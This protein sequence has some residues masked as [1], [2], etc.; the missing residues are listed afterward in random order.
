MDTGT[1]AP[2]GLANS[3]AQ[4]DKTTESNHVTNNQGNRRPGKRRYVRKTPKGDGSPIFR[5]GT[6]DTSNNPSSTK[7]NGDQ[8]EA[9]GSDLPNGQFERQMTNKTNGFVPLPQRNRRP[10][11]V[12]LK[13]DPGSKI[14]FP[15]SRENGSVPA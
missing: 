2:D 11:K 14:E 15:P 5:T 1:Q 9:K 12:Y 10:R 13:K 3:S 7:E 4:G 8:N 6:V